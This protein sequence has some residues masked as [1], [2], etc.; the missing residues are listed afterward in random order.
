MGMAFRL[1]FLPR[2]LSFEFAFVAEFLLFRLVFSWIFGGYALLLCRT[3]LAVVLFLCCHCSCRV[4]VFVCTVAGAVHG[5]D[6]DGGVLVLV[7]VVLLLSYRLR[8][9]Y[10]SILLFSIPSLI[11]TR[12]NISILL[13]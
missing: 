10:N 9:S 11:R 13:P 3:T 8:L 6:C 5:L 4:F 12:F 7:Y 1:L 2:C